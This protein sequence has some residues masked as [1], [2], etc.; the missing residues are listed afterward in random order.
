MALKFTFIADLHLKAQEPLSTSSYDRTEEKLRVLRQ[1]AEYAVEK[2]HDF[3]VLGGDIFDNR[4]P[5]DRL[6]AKMLEAINV[7]IQ[8]IIM[9]GN[10][11]TNLKNHAYESIQALTYDDSWWV[12]V[13]DG[14]INL[15][16]PDSSTLI[17]IVPYMDLERVTEAVLNPPAGSEVK[18]LLGH[19]DLDGA[20]SSGQSEYKIPTLLRQHHL[21]Q[22][23]FTFLGHIHNRQEHLGDVNWMYVGSPVYNTFGEVDDTKPKGFLSVE[24]SNEL[25]LSYDIIPAKTTGL[26][27]LFIEEG[28]LDVDVLA[29][30]G[31]IIKVIFR[32]SKSFVQGKEVQEIRSKIKAMEGNDLVKVIFESRLTDLEIQEAGEDEDVDSD[33]T[34]SLERLCTE[35]NKE[36]LL[37]DGIK[38]VE[39]A[40][41]E[42]GQDQD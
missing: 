20:I 15:V 33:L 42:I 7:G 31:E 10:H 25:E 1:A 36:K 35:K 39:E 17:R 24:L 5:P 40:Q 32:G 2:D 16:Y 34:V 12:K 3:L 18:I 22:Y 4:E 37:P 38:L 41:N 19:W 6:R 26:D 14:P 8:V 29:L 28:D 13:V 9:V 30:R 21:E 27:S 23:N 11:E